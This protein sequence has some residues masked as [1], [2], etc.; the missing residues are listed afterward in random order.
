[1]AVAGIDVGCANIAVVI[2]DKGCLC[3][4]SL[5]ACGEEVLVALEAA[6]LEACHG[7]GLSQDLI[8]GVVATG[9]GCEVVAFARRR[10]SEVVCQARGAFRLFPEARTVLN[11]GA[12]SA[13]AIRLNGQG[14]VLSFITN[15]RCAAGA[16]LFLESMARL[17]ELSMEE[18]GPLSLQAPRA[19]EVSSRCAVF[20]ESEVISHVHRGVPREEILAGIHEA[21]ADR[22]LEIAARVGLRREVVATG[23]LAKNQALLRELERKA[24]LPILRPQ[25]PQIM[26]ALGAALLAWEA[27]GE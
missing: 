5:R 22:I 10:S 12:E 14:R 27:Q 8:S 15:D 20:A 2:W 16:G 24:G 13:R 19:E 6:L 21:L 17:L 25:E 7:A 26:G 3:S 4:W 18:V 1:M 23:G 9:V 11:M